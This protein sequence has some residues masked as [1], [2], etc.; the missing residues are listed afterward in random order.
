MSVCAYC[1]GELLRVG[2]MGEL[3]KYKVGKMGIISV[4]EMGIPC[5][6]IV[7]LEDKCG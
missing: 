2:E 1:E 5:A 6:W 3:S 7:T 4:G